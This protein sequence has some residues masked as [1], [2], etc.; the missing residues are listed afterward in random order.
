MLHD[1][2]TLSDSTQKKRDLALMLL[3]R[4]ALSTRDNYVLKEAS[5]YLNQLGHKS[6][7]NDLLKALMDNTMGDRSFYNVVIRLLHLVDCHVRGEVTFGPYIGEAV[8]DFRHS[9][10]VWKFPCFFMEQM[11][12]ADLRHMVNVVM[13]LYEQDK[14]CVRN[15]SLFQ[16]MRNVLTARLNACEDE[17]E[18]KSIQ[19]M[20]NICNCYFATNV[21]DFFTE[22]THPTDLHSLLNMVMALREESKDLRLKIEPHFPEMRDILTEVLKL[23][24]DDADESTSIQAMLNTVDALLPVT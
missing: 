23:F 13:A 20:L 16:H 1:I 5:Q 24:G 15:V 9:Y 14:P 17:E 3:M 22:N 21:L 11:P 8:D 19:D 12:L 6:W 7:N 4:V 2:C 18:K 10:V